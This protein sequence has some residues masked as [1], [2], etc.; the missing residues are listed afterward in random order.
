[1]FQDNNNKYPCPLMKIVMQETYAEHVT[2]ES[3]LPPACVDRLNIFDSL[4]LR[5]KQGKPQ[6]TLFRE[7]DLAFEPRSSVLKASVLP[8]DQKWFRTNTIGDNCL[9]CPS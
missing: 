7:Y 8:L 3:L 4:H 6:K 5:K 2:H 1:M 9:R